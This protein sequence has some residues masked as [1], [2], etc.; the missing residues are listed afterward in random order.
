MEWL[1]TRPKEARLVVAIDSDRL[2][3][4]SG[5]LGRAVLTDRNGRPWTPVAYRGDDLAFR[6]KFR[7]APTESS[8]LVV[9]TRPEGTKAPIDISQITDVLARNEGGDPLDLSLA[10]FFRK[11][12]RQIN[13]PPQDLRRFKDRLLSVLDHVPQAAEKIVERWRRPDDW[14]RGQV[15]ALA[16]LA[17]HPEFTLAE[18]WPDELDPVGFV[19]HAVTLLVGYP[20]VARDQEVV[21]ELIREA[22]RP[23]MR[24]QLHWLSSTREELAAYLVLRLFASELG[25]QNPSTQLAGL[26]IF[27]PETPLLEM[28]PLATQVAAAVRHKTEVW[29]RV[30]QLAEA[31]LT[32]KRMK[33]IMDLVPASAQTPEAC[34]K[35]ALEPGMAPVIAKQYLRGALLEFLRNPSSRAGTVAEIGESLPTSE[36]KKTLA[37]LSDRGRECQSAIDFLRAAQ[38]LEDRI[39][40]KIPAF[41]HAEAL[42]DWYVANGLQQCELDVAR[43][44][45]YLQGMEDEEIGTAGW[46]YLFGGSGDLDPALG[47]LKERVRSYLDRLDHVLAKFVEDAPGSLTGSPRSALGLLKEKLGDVVRRIQLG[48]AEGRVWLLLFDGMRFDTWEA[49]VLPILAQHFRVHSEARLCV[50][51]SFTKEA[52]TSLFAGHRAYD[53]RGYGGK[54]TE[55]ERVLLARNLGISQ[56]EMSSK[57]RFVTEADTTKARKRM[58][59]EDKD[60][61]EVNV[62]IYPISD[63]CHEYRKDLAL[64]QDRIRTEILGNKAEG[65]R[66]ILDDLL[67]R[68][69][70]E[71]TVLVTSD[72]GFIELFTGDR[73]SVTEAEAQSAG[74]KLQHDV[75][76]RYV[77]SFSPAS[78][79]QTVRVAGSDGEYFLPVGRAWFGREGA[80]NEPRYEHGGVS[81]AEMVVPAALLE[82]VTE[83]VARVELVDLPSVDLLVEEDAE[84]TLKFAVQNVG[85]V[86]V[87]F[88]LSVHDNL[89]TELHSRRSRL[90]PQERYSAAVLVKGRYSQTSVGELDPSGTLTGVTL[91]VRH[92]NLQ[93]QW[94]EPPD[95][96]ETVRVRVKPKK[97]RLEAEA[98]KVFDDL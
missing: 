67:R 14:G 12:C 70:P 81:L 28:E 94:I 58:G 91:H 71:D 23:P 26:R 80:S 42:L 48:L 46:N 76:F 92:T 90:A 96:F 49:V 21:Q 25:L 95:G 19:A 36:A 43:A 60:A 13:F 24:S 7:K 93:G 41:A 29:A 97:T 30:Q 98:L 27:S 89:R 63:E 65:V 8:R 40:I 61:K 56:Q 86:P 22:A 52:R 83:K 44:Y 10:A 32:S 64:F 79:T 5:L 57:L 35:A 75:R 37:I 34:V 85:N 72:H 62:L 45:H 69:R 11:V 74:R 77:R 55:D 4:D 88:E 84:V 87:E 15:A 39:S 18:L 54:P 2:I 20:E 73:I 53:W 6:L 16:L 82:R 47:S 50:L 1:A 59:F 3:C 78:A 9:L 66:G 68:V 38:R 33:R 17:A 31:F 51:P